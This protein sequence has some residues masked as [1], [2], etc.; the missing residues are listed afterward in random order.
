MGAI[1]RALR[2]ALLVVAWFSVLSA[3]V[4]MVGLT[5]GGGMGI[6]HRWL[7]G[8]GFDSYAWP[9][10]ILGVVVGL[11]SALRQYTTFD[12]AITF[13]S[14][15]LYALPIFWVAVLPAYAGLTGPKSASLP[16]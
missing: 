2:I 13:V 16:E 7:D 5:F 12:Y 3:L 14:F 11:L 9:G 4:G 6:P 8:T 10:V 15:V 1:P